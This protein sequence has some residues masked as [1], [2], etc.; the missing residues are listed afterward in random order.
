MKNK[1]P[2][3]LI[4]FLFCNTSCTLTTAQQ[5][6]RNPPTDFF[7][8]L[9]ST[10]NVMNARYWG[11]VDASAASYRKEAAPPNLKAIFSGNIT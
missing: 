10:N 2:F 4:I 7:V 3:L 1:I 11:K 8:K 9:G 6:L 5:G